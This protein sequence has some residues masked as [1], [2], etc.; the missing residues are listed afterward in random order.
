M[1]AHPFFLSIGKMAAF[2]GVVCVS[3]AMVWGAAN[4]AALGQTEKKMEE[5]VVLSAPRTIKTVVGR[6]SS[7]GAPIENIELRRQVSYADLDLAEEA[8]VETLDKRIRETARESC[9]QLSNLYPTGE[10]DEFECIKLAIRG[11]KD[12]RDAAIAVS[13]SQ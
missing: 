3:V 12:Q 9:K 4:H 10:P 7:T 13:A 6:S 8:D 1:T 5:I 11:A 2:A